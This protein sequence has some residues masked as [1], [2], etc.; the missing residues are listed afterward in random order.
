MQSAIAYHPWR[1]APRLNN[2]QALENSA[3]ERQDMRDRIHKG[4]LQ[5]LPLMN[6][7]SK[8]LLDL[9]CGSGD[10]AR[11]YAA[12]GFNVTPTSFHPE[13]FNVPGLRCERV[14]LNGPMPFVDDSFDCVTLQEV[15]EHLENVPHLFREVHRVLKPGGSFILTTPNR[16][17]LHSRLKYLLTGFF[18]GCRKPLAADDAHPNWHV[19]DFQV[20]LWI[21][22]RA[23]F[24]FAGAA[25]SQAKAMSHLLY[26]AMYPA[27]WGG[28][29]LAAAEGRASREECIELFHHMMGRQVLLNENLILHFKA[30]AAGS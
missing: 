20:L 6:A 3:D 4:I 1:D 25:R 8:R 23:G 27:L 29:R 26:W 21:G 16:L 17:N 5:L 11:R 30:K 28:T 18:R 7:S 12:L 9:S 13:S 15:V 10:S 19:L 22:K 2:R 14:D 24:E